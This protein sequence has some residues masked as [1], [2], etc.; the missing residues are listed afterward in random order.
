[1]KKAVLLLTFA[2][3]FTLGYAQNVHTSSTPGIENRQSQELLAISSCAN[4]VGTPSNES[5]NAN[6][7]LMDN[8]D[9]KNKVAVVP[10]TYVRDQNEASY[11]VAKKMQR[12]IIEI[13]KKQIP[14]FMYLDAYTIDKVLKDNDIKNPED[15]SG[16]KLCELLGVE[17]VISGVIMIE[18]KGTTGSE[19]ST[20]TK[21]KALFSDKKYT[22]VNTVSNSRNTYGTSVTINIF[23]RKNGNIYSKDRNSMTSFEDAYKATV[24]WLAKHS[25]LYQD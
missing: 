6:L 22:A 19:M 7:G 2:M 10:F 16:E 17:Y 20:A 3:A 9:Y 18:Q 11:E 14:R 24:K 25:P 8:Q 12:E 23:D 13:F 1:M 5:L 15:I 4:I 21:N